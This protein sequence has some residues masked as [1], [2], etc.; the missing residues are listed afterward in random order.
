[1]KYLIDGV[2]K[3]V[4][5]LA[6]Q[7]K[8]LRIDDEYKVYDTTFSNIEGLDLYE[9]NDYVLNENGEKIYNE[10]DFD[11]RRMKITVDFD[12]AL[13]WCDCYVSFRSIPYELTINADT[14]ETIESINKLLER[15]E[16]AKSL[17]KKIYLGNMFSDEFSDVIKNYPNCIN[18]I[19]TK[20]DLENIKDY[21]YFFMGT[22]VYTG[23][24]TTMIVGTNSS[25]GKFSCALNVKKYYEEKGEKVVLIHTEET[26]PFLDD[27]DGT[28]YG[29][30]RNFS[31]LSTDEDFMYLQSMVAKIYDEQRPERIIF[32]TQSG[33]G[34][35]GIINSY[36][37]TENGLKMKGLWDSFIYRSFGL[38]NVVV[39]SNHNRL[40]VAKRI[41]EYFN[42]QI[43][44]V[45]AD[46]LYV[47]PRTYGED[48]I[49]NYTTEDK[50]LFYKT[51]PKCSEEE[52]NT[53][54]NGI[55]LEYPIVEI[56]TNY[57][58]VQDKVIAFKNSEDFKYFCSAVY[59]N[60][61]LGRIKKILS[62]GVITELDELTKERIET[63]Y[64][65]F[66]IT[67]DDFKKI[68]KLIEL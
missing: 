50:S 38:N 68:K 54:L 56:K 8:N 18:K 5:S 33:F 49:I 67:E 30:C 31:E 32:V 60:K 48:D 9:I 65:N 58:N 42:T 12:S 51:V 29:F 37:D 27:Q 13:E 23:F 19:I 62:L 39:C 66:N 21:R 1:M 11:T 28:I 59:A 3:S 47:N 24:V 22:S 40:D 6:N 34:L 20:T 4:L 57:G 41:I 7:Y 26:Y 10:N 14:S 45:S 17:N 25:S 63:K 2:N 53:A 44:N 46:I 15:I 36:Q 52:L 61:I 35:D 64:P 55:S 43:S 16:K